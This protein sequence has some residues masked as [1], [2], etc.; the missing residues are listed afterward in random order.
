MSWT[1]AA[2]TGKE[3]AK[4]SLVERLTKETVDLLWDQIFK[5]NLR[6]YTDQCMEEHE[7]KI[8]C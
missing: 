3:W 1:V 7:K 8:R 2:A 5:G 4:V 6:V